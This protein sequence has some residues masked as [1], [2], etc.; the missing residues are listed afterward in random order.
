MSLPRSAARRANRTEEVPPLLE[1]GMTGP[2]TQRVAMIWSS[3]SVARVAQR[4]PYRIE[5]PVALACS[6]TCSPSETA[7][8]IHASMTGPDEGATSTTR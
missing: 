3:R 5:I 6:D 4:S 8:R 7:W 2:R 1:G